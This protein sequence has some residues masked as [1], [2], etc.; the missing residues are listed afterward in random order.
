MFDLRCS[1]LV[2]DAAIILMS[3]LIDITDFFVLF[4]LLAVF[5]FLLGVSSSPLFCSNDQSPK[6]CASISG[7]HFYTISL[8]ALHRGVSSFH[9]E[10]FSCGPTGMLVVPI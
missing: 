5:L 2:Y 10:V 1:L 9:G 7:A 6:T 3:W 8:E 4:C